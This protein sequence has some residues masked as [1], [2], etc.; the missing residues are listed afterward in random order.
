MFYG[1]FKSRFPVTSLLYGESRYE[2]AS[3]LTVKQS[4]SLGNLLFKTCSYR[5]TFQFG[6][7]VRN[8]LK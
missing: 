3:L 4:P 7:Q 5:G 6:A 2:E 8:T 1:Y